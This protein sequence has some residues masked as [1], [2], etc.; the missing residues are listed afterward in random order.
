MSDYDKNRKWKSPEGELNELNASEVLN[1][2]PIPNKDNSED[3]A[4]SGASFLKTADGDEIT[5]LPKGLAMRRN[6]R[7][8]M[9]ETN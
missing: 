7:E 4:S 1:I 2:K 6:I 5:G 3:D 8:V 9:D